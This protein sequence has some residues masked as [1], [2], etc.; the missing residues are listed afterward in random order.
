[1]DFQ[2]LNWVIP[3]IFGIIGTLTGV[4]VANV[5][6]RRKERR[7]AFIDFYKAFI[8]I[9]HYLHGG[10]EH[11]YGVIPQMTASHEIA[12]TIFQHYLRKRDV[13]SFDE[14]WNE[15]YG[16]CK[17]YYEPIQLKPEQW[18][19]FQEELLKK[20]NKFLAIAEQN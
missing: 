20:L 18:P 10:R 14:A 4:F 3:G 7:D 11:P 16:E 17:K 12:K 8:D 2:V 6:Q 13:R 9:I 1:M 15:Y 5:F 19:Q